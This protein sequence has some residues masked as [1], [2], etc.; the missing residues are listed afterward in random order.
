MK[1]ILFGGLIIVMAFTLVGCEKASEYERVNWNLSPEAV[2]E[3]IRGFGTYTNPMFRYELRVPKGWIYQDDAVDL[4]GGR[5][6]VFYPDNKKLSDEY[7]GA[8]IVK[9]FVNWNVGH[10]IGDYFRREV[11]QDLWDSKIEKEIIMI[12]DREGTLLREV[13]G[14]PEAETMD[15][16]GLELNDRIVE[17]RLL[18]HSEKTKLLLNSINFYGDSVVNPEE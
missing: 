10:S 17:I 15:V 4:E 12:D 6:V 14:L 8:V 18:D 2:K 11:E 3:G 5:R 13:T 1:K 7:Y 16:I 9:G